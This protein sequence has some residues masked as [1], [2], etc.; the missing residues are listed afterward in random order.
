MRK[1]L[2]IFLAGLCLSTSAFAAR[3]FPEQWTLHSETEHVK[4]YI[5]SADCISKSNGSEM[6]NLLV[7]VE[8]KTDKEVFVNFAYEN[9]YADGTKKITINPNDEE[10]VVRIVVKPSAALEGVCYPT[11]LNNQMLTIF[12][13]NK[14]VKGMTKLEKFSIVSLKSQIIN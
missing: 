13:D 2:L 1:Y 8:N 9:T 10:N 5:K 3:V 6:Q 12:L 7:R 11:E 14:A 4:I